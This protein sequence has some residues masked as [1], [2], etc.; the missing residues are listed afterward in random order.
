MLLSC[1]VCELGWGAPLAL[2]PLLVVI[3]AS[4][5]VS[6][7]ALVLAEMG[8]PAGV[9]PSRTGATQLIMQ[10]LQAVANA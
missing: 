7:V 5:L 6:W 3:I 10:L 8:L 2:L 9:P 4:L 1:A